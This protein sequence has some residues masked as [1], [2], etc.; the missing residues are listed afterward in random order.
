MIALIG[1]QKGGVGKSTKAVNIAGYLILKQGKTAIIVDA[2]DQ[3]SI[4]TWYNDRQNVEGLPHIP[5][6]AASGKI[7][8]TL[9]ELDRHYDYVIVDTAGRDSAE[10]RSGLLAADLF[11]SPLRPSQMDLDTVGY[12]SEMFATAQEYNE[13]VKGYIVLNMCPTNIF[14]NEANEAAQ[15]LSEYPELTLVS[16]RLC[17]RKIYRDAWG[18]AIT[19]HEA[20][21]AKAQAEIESLVKEV[22]L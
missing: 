20:H 9:L 21:N 14:I 17:D 16:N 22:I 12:L 1:S 6:V 5:V 8:E 11:L 10:L 2:D 13:K 15:V 7:K 19:V 4:M 3:K 18:E